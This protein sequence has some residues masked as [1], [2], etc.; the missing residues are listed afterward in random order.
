MKKIFFILIIFLYSIKGM[1]QVFPT[2]ELYQLKV[3]ILA[4]PVSDKKCPVIVGEYQVVPI[5]P[6]VRI[7]R[8]KWHYLEDMTIE[9]YAD[10]LSCSIGVGFEF[11]NYTLLIGTIHN[12]FYNY[13]KNNQAQG[14]YKNSIEIGFIITINKARNIQSVM[15]VDI[16]NAYRNGAVSLGLG[17]TF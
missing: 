8:G 4:I 10:Q 17:W 11:Y 14:Y 5:K 1:S 6:Y 3:G 2:V 13:K 15:I 16:L 9:S 7:L 12:H